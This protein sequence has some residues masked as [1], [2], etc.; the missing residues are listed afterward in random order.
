MSRFLDTFYRN[1][2]NFP[3]N[4]SQSLYYEET[5]TVAQRIFTVVVGLLLCTFFQPLLHSVAHIVLH[6][7]WILTFTGILVYTIFRLNWFIVHII[8]VYCPCPILG[9][10]N[11]PVD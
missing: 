10:G 2:D 6:W 11:A 8:R 7:I 1:R 9:F 5:G 4:L 3:Y